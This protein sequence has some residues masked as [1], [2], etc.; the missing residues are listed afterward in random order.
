MNNGDRHVDPAMDRELADVRTTALRHIADHPPTIGVIGVSGTGKSST[1]NALFRTDLP[2]SHTTACTKEF[3]TV[4]VSVDTTQGPAQGGRAA[5]RV[6]DAPGLGEDVRRDS[7]YLRMYRA[8]LPACDVILWV[9]TARNRAVALD[10]MYLE[11]L[12]EYQ[13]RIVFGINQVDLI[14]PMNWVRRVNL[15]SEEQEENLLAVIEDRKARLAATLGRARP[16]VGYSAGRAYRLQ[17][18]FTA[19]IEACPAKRSWIFSA[20]KNFR[21]DQFATI[22]RGGDGATG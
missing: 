9:L 16:V 22:A 15:P 11:Q 8:N 12:A 1:I 5:L 21:H 6:V 10:Q 7:D 18:L 19:L 2:I 4:D 3:R 14:G 13:D 17:E 20:I